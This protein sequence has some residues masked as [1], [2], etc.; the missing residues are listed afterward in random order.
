MPGSRQAVIEALAGFAT[1]LD[2][3]TNDGPH[4][5]TLVA[6]AKMLTVFTAR[7]LDDVKAFARDLCVVARQ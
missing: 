5:V 6:R 3:V 1:A 4:A 2:V 7:W